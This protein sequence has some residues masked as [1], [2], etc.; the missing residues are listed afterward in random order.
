[1]PLIPFIYLEYALEY[2]FY[3]PINIDL[4][5]NLYF[6]VDSVSVFS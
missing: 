2:F 1:M 3:T 6:V 5:C 4:A